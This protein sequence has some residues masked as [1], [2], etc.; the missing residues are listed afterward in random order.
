MGTVKIMFAS[1]GAYGH[2]YPMMPLAPISGLQRV[3]RCRTGMAVRT[4]C[5]P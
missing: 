5:A 3:Q 2:L 1:L 4:P